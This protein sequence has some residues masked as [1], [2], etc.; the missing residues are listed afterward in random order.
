M[1]QLARETGLSREELYQVLP[2]K[3]N[4]EFGTA[5]QVIRALGLKLCAKIAHA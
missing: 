5:M 4:P 1:S 2:A 3:G